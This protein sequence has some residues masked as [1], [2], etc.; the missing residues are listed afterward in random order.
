M[1]RKRN[2]SETAPKPIKAQDAMMLDPTDTGSPFIP[3]GTGEGSSGVAASQPPTPEEDLVVEVE[4]A[5]S[6]SAIGSAL[7]SNIAGYLAEGAGAAPPDVALRGVLRRYGLLEA[8][9]VFTEGQVQA[10]QAR[11]DALR[12]ATA[13]GSASVEQASALERLPPLSSFM[14]LRF[15]G[16]TP[17]SEVT[18]ALKQLPEVTK[19]VIVPKAAPPMLALS[20][21]DPTDPQIGDGPLT[22]DPATGLESQWYLHRTRVPQAWQYSRGANVVV[23]DIDWGCRTSHQEFRASIDRCYNAV[24]GGADVTQG[25]H[26]AH[27][28]A[29]LGIAG[30]RADGVGMAGYAPEA[31]LWAVQGD[32]G[33]N[34]PVF[35]EPWAEA[36][37]FVRRTNSANRRKVVIVE[38][39]TTLGGNFEQ[40]PSVHRAIRA[41]IAD[42]CVVCV[43]S[44]N[45]NRPADRTDSD[46]P[47][48]PTGSILVGATAYDANLNKRAFFSNYGGRVVVSAP[49]DLNHDLTCGHASDSSYR[50]GFGGTSGATPKVAGTVALMLSVNPD[51]THGDVRDI[52]SGTGSTLVEDPG[53]PIGTFLN[54]EAAVA[55]ALRR[56]SLSQPTE[57]LRTPA[58]MEVAE[59]PKT[60]SV[61][62][63]NRRQSQLV[64][65]R[66]TGGPISWETVAETPIVADAASGEQLPAGDKTLR[67]FRESVEGTLTQQDRILIVGQAIQMLDNFYVHRP[68]KEAIHAVRPIQRLRVLQRRLMQESN[69]PAGE[70]DELAFH[71]TLTQVFNSVRDLHTNYQLPQPYR[72]YIAYLPFEVAPFYENGVRR[73]VVTRVLTGHQFPAPEFGS[74][75]ELFYW[76]GMAIERAVRANAEQTAG[77]NDAARHARGVSSL[78]IRPMNTALPPDADFVDLEFLPRHGDPK[79]LSQRR[80][81]RQQ[82]FVRYA[83]TTS[84][85]SDKTAVSAPLAQIQPQPPQAPPADISFAA[86]VSVDFSRHSMARSASVIFDQ[87]AKIVPPAEAAQPAAAVPAALLSRNLGQAAVLGLDNAADAVR[88]ARQLIFDSG[89]LRNLQSAN[90]GEQVSGFFASAS[91]DSLEENPTGTEI[92]VM[93]PWNAA[94]RART[95]DIGGVTYGHIQIRTFHVEDADG[96]VAE[97]VRLLGSTPPNGL[98]LDVRGNGGGSILAA[99]RLLQTLTATRIE[100]ERMQFVVTPGTLDLS[101]NNPVGS[102]IPLDQWRPSLEEAVETGSLYSHAF[103]LTDPV[104]CNSIGQRYYGPVVLVVDGNC[105]S[106]TDMFAAGFQDHRIGKILGVAS[107]TGAGGANV[108]EHWLLN[109]VL[110]TGWGLKPLP[111]NASMR[112]AIRQCLR[113]GPRAGALLEDFGVVPDEIHRPTRADVMEGD[114]ELLAR[115][116]ELLSKEPRREISVTIGASD[117]AKPGFRLVSIN[118]VGLTRLDF[119]VEGK[120][121]G[122]VSL[123]PDTAG[124]ATLTLPMK[125]GSNINLAGFIKPNDLVAVAVHRG[126]VA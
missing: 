47:F 8:R 75:S 115:A 16:G 90:F 91:P 73:Y 11:L 27:G 28:T 40:I 67:S 31:S 52:L 66:N 43:A 98:I 111:N 69:I 72:D 96:F 79:N 10:E 110:P 13:I 25:S 58:G 19:A 41:A 87:P 126:N 55:E 78:T 44:G 33:P 109:L 95:I 29:V 59:P 38:V 14:R 17:P 82:W 30:A 49:G 83:P 103:P 45:G 99:E 93:V 107:N 121:E 35:E 84:G 3:V 88:E 63:I 9:S 74:G 34:A 12:A 20:E 4:L 65:P 97:F 57:A 24:D 64:L 50:N 71:N 61:H 105:Y 70:R 108:W 100:P 53:K 89:A 54:A 51:L 5:P 80:Q 26:A 7:S 6:A 81:M 125:A 119:Y 86:N 113:V 118:T 85:G 77:S 114:R 15:P 106:A 102:Q 32:S 1:A 18:T 21:P 94:F 92:S 62:G 56:R 42:G 60:K 22:S 46:E 39:Q 124:K 48:D 2:S 123:N 116:A 101:R 117:P 23:A 122:N 36:V 104:S 120:P 37:D 76:N 112:V 68:L